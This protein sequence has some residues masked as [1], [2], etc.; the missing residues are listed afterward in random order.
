MWLDTSGDGIQLKKREFKTRGLTS[1]S[2]LTFRASFRQSPAGYTES[3][4][5]VVQARGARGIV[6][7]SDPSSP[8]SPVAAARGPGDRRG[9]H[10]TH[11]ARLRQPRAGAESATGHRWGIIVRAAAAW[12]RQALGAMACAAAAR[13]AMPHRLPPLPDSVP[14]RGYRCRARWARCRP[15]RTPAPRAAATGEERS[16]GSTTPRA[17]RECATG[18]ENLVYP[19]GDWRNEALRV[20][21]DSDRYDPPRLARVLRPRF[22]S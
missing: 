6:E 12:V 1:L 9:L 19:A 5:P 11:R 16:D 3:S 7:P 13:T 10:L 18:E 14:T 8:T 22:L 15:R 20:R 21:P 4:S 17:P 2:G